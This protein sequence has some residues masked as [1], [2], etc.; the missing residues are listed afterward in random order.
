MTEGSGFA[1]LLN[2]VQ[3]KVSPR[4]SEIL[5]M[6]CNLYSYSLQ[7]NK[8]AVKLFQIFHPQVVLIGIWK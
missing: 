1:Q 8:T 4:M 5:I 6:E 3:T 7:W 2:P